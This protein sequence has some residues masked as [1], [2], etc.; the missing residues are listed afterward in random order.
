MKKGMKNIKKNNIK[1]INNVTTNSGIATI[2]IT[3]ILIEDH[4][5][6]IHNKIT[7]TLI[8]TIIMECIH[9]I[10]NTV[11]PHLS[12]IKINLMRVIIRVL[13]IMNIIGLKEIQIITITT[14]GIDHHK[15][16][17][18]LN[19]IHHLTIMMPI[20]IPIMEDNHLDIDELT[21]QNFVLILIQ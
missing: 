20:A 19:K 9:L 21:I 7:I 3:M 11:N 2:A 15:C 18:H 16:I 17:L 10:S 4:K 6:T 8:T 13:L 1:S 14:I 5:E 12:K